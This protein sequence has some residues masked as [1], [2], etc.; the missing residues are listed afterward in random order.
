MDIPQKTMILPVLSK[1]SN[2]EELND[3]AQGK[4]LEN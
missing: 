3:F 2:K 1:K 4:L